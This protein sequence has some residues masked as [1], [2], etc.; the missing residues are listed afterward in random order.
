MAQDWQIEHATG[1][2]AVSGRKL[3]EGEEFYTVLF[4]AGE[5]FKRADYSLDV[6]KEPPEGTFCYFRSR[7]PVREKRKRLLVDDDLLVNFF[8]R[9]AEETEPVRVQFRFVLALILMRKRQ[10]R[11]EGSATEDGAEI[12]RMVLLCDQSAHRVVN[13]RLNDREID[14]V[15][16]QLGGIL[17]SDMHRWALESDG[18]ESELLATDEVEDGLP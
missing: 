8:R 4:E 18:E 1:V 12:W 5:S 10:L 15:S 14:E 6:W 2:C 3:E 11:Y 7:V 16:R 9:L 17:H 13:P